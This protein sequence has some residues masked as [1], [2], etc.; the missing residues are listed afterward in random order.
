[1]TRQKGVRVILI[2]FLVAITII[3]C[4]KI[5]P[6]VNME[7]KIKYEKENLTISTT[8]IP[9]SLHASS[10]LRSRDEDII[11]ALFEGLVEVTSDGNVVPALA[12]GWKISEDELRY[13]FLLNDNIYWSD[14]TK[15]VASD[16][17]DYFEYLF[18]PNNINYTSDELYNIYGVEDFKKGI[19]GFDDVGIYAQDEDELIIQLVVK[20]PKFL[21][22]LSK[23]EYRLRDSDDELEN[24]IENYQNIR[25]TG[26]YVI[27]SVRPYTEIKLISNNKYTLESV[28]AKNITLI[29]SGDNIRDFAMYNTN[30]IDIVT[31]PPIT[32]FSEGKLINEITYTTSKDMQYMV[33]NSIE[34]IGKY[35]DFRKAIYIDLST[36]L[37]DSYLIK[38]KFATMDYREISN[39]EIEESILYERN[40]NQE[41]NSIAISKNLETA[42]SL[43][44][45]IP[46][47]KNEKVRVIGSNNYENQKLVEFLALEFEKLGLEVNFKLYDEEKEL[48]KKLKKGEFTIYIDSINLE[49]E[50]IN[51]KINIISEY[52]KDYEY[53]IFSMY[54]KNNYWCKSD[55]IKEIYIDNNGNMIFRKMIY[56]N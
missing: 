40:Y 20:D 56:K 11:N 26:A 33:F 55:R 6:V 42:R 36:A 45:G 50:N 23:P 9:E 2:V 41:Y 16:F 44:S 39:E 28:N 7:S 34:G 25:Y 52:Y 31:N 14:G 10:Y 48:N 32:A 18:S 22:K 46:K 35:L 24:Y 43:L 8:S 30:K 21:Q 15:I 5:T 3:G 12:Q 47:D 1:M 27:E 54:T 4:S 17:L 29:N 19:K 49:D 38:N 53:S 51:N 13:S 37:M